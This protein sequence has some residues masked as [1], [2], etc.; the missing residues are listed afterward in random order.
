[1]FKFESEFEFELRETFNPRICF[2]R[3]M[4]LKPEAASG[5]ATAPDAL[6]P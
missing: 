4:K 5:A 6:N 1:L 2:E 3:A